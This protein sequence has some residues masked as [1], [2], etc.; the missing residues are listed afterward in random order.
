MMK[1][2]IAFVAALSLMSTGFA[3]TAFSDS[4]ETAEIVTFSAKDSSA[5][6]TEEVSLQA[7]IG[8]K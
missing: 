6:D 1:K 3:Q 2:I 4:E 8:L 5:D 7:P